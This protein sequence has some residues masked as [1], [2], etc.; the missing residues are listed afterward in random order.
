MDADISKYFDRIAH[1]RLRG[2]LDLRIKDGVIRR[3]IDK[4]LKAGIIDADCT[5][6]LSAA[7][8][9]GCVLD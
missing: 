7:F 2:N 9:S 4:W 8:C 5:A 1:R 3:M 6:Q